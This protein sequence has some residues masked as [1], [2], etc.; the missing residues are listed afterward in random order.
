M[1]VHE[2]IRPSMSARPSSWAHDWVYHMVCHPQKWVINSQL[3]K[4]EPFGGYN[5]HASMDQAIEKPKTNGGF[6]IASSRIDPKYVLFAAA[7]KIRQ[8]LGRIPRT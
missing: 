7:L 2:T 5:R 3:I 4:Q 1:K 6:M 8:R